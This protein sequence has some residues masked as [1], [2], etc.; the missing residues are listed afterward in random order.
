MEKTLRPSSTLGH[1]APGAEQALDAGAPA[2]A[3]IPSLAWPAFALP[4]ESPMS[5]A[6]ELKRMR[7]IIAFVSAAELDI[8]SQKT[9]PVSCFASENS[10]RPEPVPISTIPALTRSPRTAPP[11]HRIAISPTQAG[12]SCN[13]I[14]SLEHA[15]QQMLL[16]LI[17]RFE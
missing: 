2:P 7:R 13:S 8:H 14:Q 10:P 17:P 12:Q 11:R 15:P 9:F 16:K 4:R 5:A 1:A 6:P 3:G